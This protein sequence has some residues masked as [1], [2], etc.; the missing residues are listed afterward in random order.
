MTKII[1]VLRFLIGFSVLM[2]IDAKTA[3]DWS[4]TFWPYWCSFAI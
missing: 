1:I 3:W 4:T 2:K